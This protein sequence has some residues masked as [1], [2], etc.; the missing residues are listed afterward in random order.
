M[1]PFQLVLAKIAIPD[2]H[3]P[4]AVDALALAIIELG[5]QLDISMT[6]SNPVDSVIGSLKTLGANPNAVKIMEARLSSL[7]DQY[8]RGV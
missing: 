4:H 6:G 5:C 8:A 3:S 2:Q 7:R 1:N